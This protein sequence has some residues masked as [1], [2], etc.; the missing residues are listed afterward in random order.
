MLRVVARSRDLHSSL[1]VFG[2]VSMI[3]FHTVINIGM[4]VG[5][6]PVVGIPLPLFSYGGSSV[7]STMGALGIILGVSM[8]RFIIVTK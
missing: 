6:F 5:L 4:V 3:F 8:R 1:M 2:I 7:L